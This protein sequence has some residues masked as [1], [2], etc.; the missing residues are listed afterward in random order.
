MRDSIYNDRRKSREIPRLAG[1]RIRGDARNGR[2][3]LKKTPTTRRI[4][5]GFFSKTNAVKDP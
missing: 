1:T 3:Y 5:G 4:G 2:N